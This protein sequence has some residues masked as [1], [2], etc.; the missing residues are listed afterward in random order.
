MLKFKRILLNR[1]IAKYIVE[2]WAD[3]DVTFEVAC[4]REELKAKW[5]AW[6]QKNH[7]VT[8]LKRKEV[9]DA[10]N[11]A[12]FLLGEKVFWELAVDVMTPQDTRFQVGDLRFRKYSYS[13]CNQTILA[14]EDD[15]W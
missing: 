3:S 10:F 2:N 15:L 7:N 9:H 13:S 5:Q 12:F 1:R 4:I 8:P 6:K 14:L 11:D